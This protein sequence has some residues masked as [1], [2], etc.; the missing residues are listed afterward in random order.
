VVEIEEAKLGKKK[1]NRG[2]HVVGVIII[3]NVER[4]VEY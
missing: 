4:T 2:H 1:F 3:G